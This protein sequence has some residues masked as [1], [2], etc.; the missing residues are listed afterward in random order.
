MGGMLWQ[1]RLQKVSERD[2]RSSDKW[3]RT[4]T[5]LTFIAPTSLVAVATAM[6]FESMRDKNMSKEGDL[7]ECMTKAFVSIDAHLRQNLET[8][9]GCTANIVLVSETLL[10]C[11]NIGDSRSVLSRSGLALEM[12]KDHKPTDEEET[13]RIKKA[14]GSVIRGR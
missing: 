11:A 5:W 13:E 9:S 10:A 14:G 12:S 1:S 3:S 4:N 8:D 2:S 6:V 7:K